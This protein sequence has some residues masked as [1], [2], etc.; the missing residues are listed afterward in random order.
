MTIPIPRHMPTFAI[1]AGSSCSGTAS[2]TG[3][4]DKVTRNRDENELDCTGDHTAQR[5]ASDVNGHNVLLNGRKCMTEVGAKG[6]P[7]ILLQ[8]PRKFRPARQA[9]GSTGDGAARCRHPFSRSTAARSL[10]L[11]SDLSVF[12][13]PL[14]PRINLR[15]ANL[16]RL[17]LCGAHAERRTTPHR[18][19]TCR[20][21]LLAGTARIG[22]CWSL[23]CDRVV[24]LS[25][26]TRSAEIRLWLESKGLAT[27]PV[28]GIVRVVD[29]GCVVECHSRQAIQCGC[30]VGGLLLFPVAERVEI[31]VFVIGAAVTVRVDPIDVG[32][33]AEIRE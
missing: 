2:L 17:W 20:V 30:T 26:P 22:S 14:A 7:S 6:A 8:L 16:R 12:R 5:H 24:K 23:R 21:I 18:L 3:H 25:W 11:E 13:R 29:R 31:A 15:S 1:K 9:R 27:T 28:A 33:I 19:A 32:L 10:L 4:P